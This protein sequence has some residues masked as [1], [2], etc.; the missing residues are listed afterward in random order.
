M[1]GLFDAGTDFKGR[2]VVEKRGLFFPKSEKGG[3][4]EKGFEVRVFRAM[5]RK[6]EGVKYEKFFAALGI[7]GNGIW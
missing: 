3:Q 4:N 1:F 6:R 7:A 5:G 2:K